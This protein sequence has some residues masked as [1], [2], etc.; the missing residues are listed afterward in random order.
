LWEAVGCS[1]RLGATFTYVYW[2]NHKRLHGEIGMVPPAEFEDAY[3]LDTRA[4]DIAG[5]D[6]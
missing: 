1:R 2:F 5:T 3:Y 6:I 4:V